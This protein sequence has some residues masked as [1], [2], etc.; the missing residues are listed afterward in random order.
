MMRYVDKST[1]YPGL[2]D[3][4][5]SQREPIEHSLETT[6]VNIRGPMDDMEKGLEVH[7]RVTPVKSLSVPKLFQT[8]FKRVLDV[9]H[10]FLKDH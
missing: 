9:F 3:E 7:Q 5:Q 4:A 1:I 10:L 8:I 6:R 2:N